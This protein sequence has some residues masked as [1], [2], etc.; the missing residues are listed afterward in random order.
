MNFYSRFT[1]ASPEL[2]ELSE[3]KF[4]EL[5]T[6]LQSLKLSD[7]PISDYNKRYL[8]EHID[9][10]KK[11]S[12]F[13]SHIFM[14]VM[15]KNVELAK[16]TIIDYGGG[17]GLLSYYA[18]LLGV[19]TVI[20]NDIYGVSCTDVAIISEK[21]GIKIDYIVEGDIEHVIEFTQ[22]KK[23]NIDFVIAN[24]VIEHIY[25]VNKWFSR[26]K[27][28]PSN[29]L[30]LICTS[31]A[32]PYNPLINRKLSKLQ[33]NAEFKARNKQWGH[34]DRDSLNSFY[35]IRKQ[36]IKKQLPD[37]D[38][39][40]LDE[41]S[42]VTRGL[43]ENDIQQEVLVFKQNG[44]TNYK[45][46]HK[47]NTCDPYTGNWI[48]QLID[49]KQLNKDTDEMGYK[50]QISKGFYINTKGGFIVSRTKIIVN[51]LTNLLG[52]GGFYLAPYYIV[53]SIFK[54]KE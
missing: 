1:S 30:R 39:K 17:S 52:F 31:H 51:Y 26:V 45:P 32:N 49:L 5:H 11:A 12:W 15:E 8:G 6:K 50:S 40:T 7:L 54:G 41:L 42:L 33:Q 23:I 21:L 29:E 46:N 28:L 27:N 20:Y 14:L 37:V 16:L 36:I 48:E 43:M 10:Y 18:K 4:D 3:R 22:E 19:G 53:S 44:Q 47:T 2:I 34:K 38:R 35:E 13:L 25:D 24:D 9:D